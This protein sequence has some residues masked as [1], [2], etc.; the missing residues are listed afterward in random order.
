MSRRTLRSRLRRLAVRAAGHALYRIGA[1][2]AL[3]MAPG[4]L[5]CYLGAAAALTGRAMM[6]A[7]N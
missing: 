2:L 5:A 1:A 7:E 6:D 3:A 4:G